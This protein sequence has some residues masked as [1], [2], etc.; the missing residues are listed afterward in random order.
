[1]WVIKENDN[2]DKTKN[3]LKNFNIHNLSKTRKLFPLNSI[4]TIH[5]FSRSQLINIKANV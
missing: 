5:L 3:D 2:F 1:M 4:L